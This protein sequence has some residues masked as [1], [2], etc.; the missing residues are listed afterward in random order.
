MAQKVFISYSHQQG[1]W[2]LDRLA[3]C[4]RGGG[5]EV[6][7]DRERFTAGKA[8]RGQMD[9]LQDQAAQSVL[10]LTPA[11]L[12]SDYCTHEMQRAIARDPDWARGLTVPI[13]RE[14]CALPLAIDQ[15][16]PLW[17]E[18]G[19]DT[20]TAPWD[21]LL[22]ACSADLGM[23]AP[24]WLAALADARSFLGRGESINLV[25]QGRVAWRPM[26]DELRTELRGLGEV[27]LESPAANSRRGL[28]REILRALAGSAVPVPP[29]P[30][31]LVTLEEQLR[32]RGTSRL[33]L[34]HFDYVARRPHHDANLFGA[35]R[36]L[37]EQRRLVLLI[38]S[39]Q[40]LPALLPPDHLL[41]T[42]HLQT[43]VLR[44]RS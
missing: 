12:A 11:Y 37:M 41:S 43:V 39:R 29:E 22:Q 2:V 31:D 20:Q 21:L 6:L 10:V 23:P 13:R 14:R 24:E 3:P 15:A 5:A 25:V 18:L 36:H 33:A 16:R 4:L 8:V 28:V 19:D 9:G 30:E 40:P 38:E 34:L 7:I 42:L 1:S 27:D 44:G 32:G 35:L 26:I 17:V